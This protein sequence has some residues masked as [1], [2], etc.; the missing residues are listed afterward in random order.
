MQPQ[1]QSLDEIL[2]QLDPAYA[3]SRG[4]YQQQQ[5]LLPGQLA[6]AKQGLEVG[7]QNAFRDVN[8]NANSKGLAFS[9]IPAAEQSRYLGEKFLP[10]VAGV[11]GDYAK[12]NFTLS[13][14]LAGLESEK[15]LKGI[16]MR[17]GQQKTLDAYMEA[18]RDRQFKAQQADLDRRA[19]AAAKTAGGVDIELRKNDRGGWEVFENGKPSKNYDLATAAALTGKDVAS[20][21]RNG[22]AQDKQAVKWYDEKMGKLNKWVQDAGG[23]ENYAESLAAKFRQELARDRS[24]AFYLGGSY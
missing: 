7:K 18:E 14:A 19:S 21:L 4:L 11:E 5:A 20:L 2:A 9:G 1:V 24:S 22:D 13:Q 12:Q 17:S 16:D 6:T 10:A 23:D 8:T 15:R 3:P